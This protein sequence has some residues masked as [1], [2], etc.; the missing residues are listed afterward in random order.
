MTHR[1]GFLITAAGSLA[2]AG[3]AH[4][5]NPIIRAV[6]FDGLAIFDARPVYALAEKLYPGRGSELSAL[7]RSRQFEY[8]WLRTLM[9]RYTDFRLVTEDALI[10]AANALRLDL[11]PANR[12]L[13]LESFLRLRCWPDVPDAVRALKESGLTLGL[14]SNMTEPMLEAGV[15]LS[16]LSDAF[17]HLF[18]TDRVQ[19][20]KPD[21][22]AYQMGV[23]GFG[24]RRDQ[25]LF[26]AFAGWDAAGAASFGYPTFWLNRQNQPGELLDGASTGV[27]VVL[28]DLVR[29]L[30]ATAL[31][32]GARPAAAASPPARS[33]L[34][35]SRYRMD[36]GSR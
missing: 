7:W 30:A 34:A 11:T 25:I 2:I 19:A 26:V 31:L 1:R 23:D 10:Y 20:Y 32:P 16:G 36:T 28:D 8:S 29:Y 18:S 4:A 24:L 3:T 33:S 22:R 12:S 27:G 35:P 14:L 15:Q 5:A 13:L 6:A 17:D 21:P 9:A